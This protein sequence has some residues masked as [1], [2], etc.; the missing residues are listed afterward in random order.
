MEVKIV[1]CNHCGYVWGLEFI[2]PIEQP[3]GECVSCGSLDVK[4]V[5][6]IKK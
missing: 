3:L 1:K 4:I 2:D 5:S 6:R